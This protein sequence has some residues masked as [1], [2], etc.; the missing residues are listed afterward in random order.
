[1]GVRVV[2]RVI[3]DGGMKKGRRV[4][5]GNEKGDERRS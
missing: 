3:E 1:M 5:E 2:V 4:V